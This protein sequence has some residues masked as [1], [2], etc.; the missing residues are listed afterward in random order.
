[1]SFISPFY[2]SSFISPFKKCH[3]GNGSTSLDLYHLAFS[4]RL[5]L[6]L[7]QEKDTVAEDGGALPVPVGELEGAADANGE[8]KLQPWRGNKIIAAAPFALLTLFALCDW[9]LAE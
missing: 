3:F 8:L 7:L 5:L 1:M 6:S 9:F 2:F 4:E